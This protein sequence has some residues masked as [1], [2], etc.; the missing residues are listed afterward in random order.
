MLTDL[1][2]ARPLIRSELN[3]NTHDDGRLMSGLLDC[4][5]T[6]DFVS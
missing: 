1:A 4:S 2:E 5:A 6:L 3:V